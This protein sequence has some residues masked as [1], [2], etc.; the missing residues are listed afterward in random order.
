MFHHLNK[1]CKCGWGIYGMTSND[2]IWV[3]ITTSD[4]FW[5]EL[6]LHIKMKLHH[7]QGFI[8][9]THENTFIEDA[10]ITQK[11]SNVIQCELGQALEPKGA[12]K[13]NN[14]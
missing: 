10:P 3:D 13:G 9:E 6:N 2:A 4:W 5:I 7:V 11:I 12:P 1:N 8:F 14:R